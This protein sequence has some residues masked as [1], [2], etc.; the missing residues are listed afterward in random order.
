MARN[1]QG[2]LSYVDIACMTQAERM[3]IASVCRKDIDR[4][5]PSKN[6]QHRAQLARSTTVLRML[7]PLL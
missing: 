7:N 4:L 6:F 5:S 1:D 3:A 2:T